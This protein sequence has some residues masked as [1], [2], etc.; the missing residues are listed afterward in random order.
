MVGNRNTNTTLTGGVSGTSGYSA[1][2]APTRPCLHGGCGVAT[3]AIL[4]QPHFAQN[5]CSQT[6]PRTIFEEAKVRA[7]QHDG[8]KNAVQ[9]LFGRVRR[10]CQHFLAPPPAR[11]ERKPALRPLLR[12]EERTLLSATP[13]GPDLK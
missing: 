5:R 13:L 10:A 12:L 7:M 3:T 11:I 8:S 6:I 9:R 4:A 2:K 1:A